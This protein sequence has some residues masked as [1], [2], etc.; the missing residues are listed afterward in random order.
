M[1]KTTKSHSKYCQSA[2]T[3]LLEQSQFRKN[4]K[5]LFGMVVRPAI[6]FSFT[7]TDAK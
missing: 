3:C 6:A 7:T 4:W 2:H 1:Y 5:P